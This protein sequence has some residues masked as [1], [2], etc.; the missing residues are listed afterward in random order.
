MGQ[1]Q[2]VLQLGE[3]DTRTNAL[4]AT[5]PPSTVSEFLVRDATVVI[6]GVSNAFICIAHTQLYEHPLGAHRTP[7]IVASYVLL[8]PFSSDQ[9]SY[10]Q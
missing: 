9:P 6:N 5:A 4:P 1:Q 8:R 3:V 2:R 7:D 10:T